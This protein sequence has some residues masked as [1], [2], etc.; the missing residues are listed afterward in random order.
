[1]ADDAIAQFTE[2]TGSSPEVADQYL[3]LTDYDAQTAMQ[4]FFENGGAPIQ[5]DPQSQSSAGRHPYEDPSGVVHIDSDEESPSEK[6]QG[7]SN[8]AA[9]STFNDDL[10]MARRLQEEF[11]SSHVNSATDSDGVRA[12]MAR[13]TETLVGPGSDLGFDDSNGVDSAVMQQLRARQQ[14]RRG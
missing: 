14:A 1:M 8:A 9:N 6:G 4:L 13:T 5:E 10:E 7:A 3:R 11:Y 2:I 12:P